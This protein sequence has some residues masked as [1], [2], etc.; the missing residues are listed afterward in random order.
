MKQNVRGVGVGTV[1]LVLIFAVLCLTVFAVLTLS[2]ANAEKTMANRTADFI[3]SYYNADTNATII[4]AHILESY[5]SGNFPEEG[6]IDASFFGVPL[7]AKQNDSDILYVSFI[8]KVNDV[9]NLSVK[10]RLSEEREMVLEWRL[11]SS[12]DWEVD[13]TLPV[14]DGT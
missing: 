4:T 6:D 7:T 9:L 10:L 14:W 13:D 2:T 12:L 5:R 1:S 8:Y 3:T 11:V